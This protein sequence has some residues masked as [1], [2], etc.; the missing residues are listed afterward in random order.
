MNSMKQ[1]AMLTTLPLSGDFHCVCETHE[2]DSAIPQ[3][4]SEQ[5]EALWQRH[6]GDRFNGTLLS[7]VRYE[8]GLLVARPVSYKACFAQH[9]DPSLHEILHIQTLAV[10]GV[11]QVNQAVL[12]AKRSESVTQYPGY[13]ELVPS[14]SV[15]T[16]FVSPEGGIDY[17]GQLLEE[18]WEEVGIPATAVKQ[19]TPFA[20]IPDA[21]GHVLDIAMQIETELS[22]EQVLAA[23]EEIPS[24][25]A[26]YVSPFW[27]PLNQLQEFLQGQ[28]SCLV[29]TSR[30]ILVHRHT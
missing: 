27:L 17:Q 23:F 8:P 4:V 28:S 1:D 25:T 2:L 11:I 18:L 5:I 22:A 16:R 15:M 3:D 24:P 7:V 29:P 13:N 12:L 19:I 14:G 20:L 10:S 26:E 21:T 9:L 6:A 30:N